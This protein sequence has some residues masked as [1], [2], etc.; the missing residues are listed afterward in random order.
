MGGK[1][2]LEGDGTRSDAVDE[3]EQLA[4]WKSM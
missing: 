4:I 1:V 2:A 3:T